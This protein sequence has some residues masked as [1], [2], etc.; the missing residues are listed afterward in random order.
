MGGHILRLVSV[1]RLNPTHSPMAVCSVYLISQGNE[2][3]GGGQTFLYSMATG[4]SFSVSRAMG[5]ASMSVSLQSI[6]FVL[7]PGKAGNFHFLPQTAARQ[8]GP[9]R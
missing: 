1:R 8:R 2:T 4:A 3:L 9:F 5:M 6:S 7:Y